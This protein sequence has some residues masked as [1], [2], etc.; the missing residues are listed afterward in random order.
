[1]AGCPEGLDPL[2]SRGPAPLGELSVE[3]L[4]DPAP[5]VIGVNSDEVDV[6]TRGGRGHHHAEKEADDLAVK[7]GNER[8][9]AE[10]IKE[11]WIRAPSGWPTPPLIEHRNDIVVVDF[12]EAPDVH[13][14]AQRITRTQHER[15]ATPIPTMSPPKETAP[16]LFCPFCHDGFEGRL[17]CPEHELALVAIDQLPRRGERRLQNV[18]FFADPRLGRGGVLLGAALVLLGFV[19]PLVASAPQTGATV[20]ASALEV[21]IDGAANLWLAPGAATVL[22]WILWRRRSREAMRAARA[23]VLGLAAGGALPLIYTTRR[24][25][26]VAESLAADV[27]WQS[28][29]WL[30]AAGLVIAAFGSRQ[31]GSA[32]G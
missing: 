24:I 30:M 2:H 21:A 25:G 27:E 31:L 12:R 6:P 23:A 15:T 17:E 11:H 16:V 29:L 4:S 32:P 14:S 5:A 7:L 18:T 28:G 10:L 20:V 19:A 22:L 13:R 26:L 1:M 3:S 8:V 9:L